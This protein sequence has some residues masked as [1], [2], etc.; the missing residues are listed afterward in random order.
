MMNQ[1]NKLYK[2]IFSQSND[3]DNIN[4][5]LVL[6]VD[7]QKIDQDEVFVEPGIHHIEMR[8]FH[9][10]NNIFFI[11]GAIFMAFVL[12]FSTDP[13]VIFLVR[14]WGRFSVTKFEIEVY[15]DQDIIV[16]I[17]KKKIRFM[18]EKYLINVISNQIE[19]V[20]LYEQRSLFALL[21]TVTLIALPLAIISLVIWL[22]N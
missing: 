17:E 13:D 4:K 8:Q 12:V 3:K 22:V 5:I 14:R 10:L 1:H 2:L 11:F 18:S 7:H 20:E 15:E 6:Y 19:N 9:F 21:G 16:N